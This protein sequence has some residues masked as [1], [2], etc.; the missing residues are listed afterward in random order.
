MSFSSIPKVA[1]SA[2]IYRGPS[3]IDGQPIMAIVTG[4]AKRSTNAKT[5]GVL[6]VFI[7]RSDVSPADAIKS[8]AAKSVCGDCKHI[9]TSCYVTIFHAP[10]NVYSTEKLDRYQDVLDR[11]AV[12]LLFAG[13]K[14][15]LGAYGDPAA[16]PI[17]FWD[18]VLCDCDAALGY[19]H[20]WRR[21]P[22]IAAYCMAS[23]DTENERFEAKLLGFRTFRVR[24]V[25]AAAM[26]GEVV[27]PAS[28]EAGV[29]TNCAACKACGGHS[30]KARADVVITVHGSADKMAKFAKTIR[31]LAA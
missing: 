21:F 26:R 30:S 2:V 7:V 14:V 8:G 31:E 18:A 20:A 23:C 27:C 13:R 28:K 29:K 11:D 3:M 16:L 9:G 22:E 24:L 10:R 15:R 5:G 25:G 6:Q 17:S 1:N 12:A 19:T 4:L